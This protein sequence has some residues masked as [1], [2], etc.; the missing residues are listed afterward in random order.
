MLTKRNVDAL[1]FDTAGPAQQIEWDGKLSGFGCRVYPTGA[2]SFVVT[3]RTES[4]LA[5]MLVLGKYG[6]LTV[7]QGRKLAQERLA[8]VARGEDPAETKRQAR[9]GDT[10]RDLCRAYLDRHAKKKR[11]S[12]REDERR[13]NKH[14]LPTLGAK[15]VADLKKTDLVRLHARISDRAP[16]EANRVLDLLRLMLNLAPD[17]GMLPE[18]AANPAAKVRK[19]KETS[20]DRW[21]TPEELPALVEAIEAE[22]SPYVVAAFK[23]YL[24]TGCRRNELLR[25]RWADVDLTRREIRLTEAKTGTRTVPLSDQAVA[26]FKEL[27]RHIGNVYVFPGRVLKAQSDAKA[28]AKPLLNV[29]KAWRRVRARLWLAMNPGRLAELREQA[30]RDVQ[31]KHVPKTPEVVEAR[32]LK[33]AEK[34]AHGPDAV[35]LHDLRRTVGAWMATSGKSLPVVGKVLGHTSPAATTVYARI[36]ESAARAALEEHGERI[37][38]LLTGQTGA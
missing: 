36:A 5:R 22:E 20:R 9:L 25:L 23:L 1:T 16:L 10:V 34:E 38:P 14:I 11:R 30:E 6:K 4:G 15:K 35:R 33:L 37:G 18:E 21:V 31:R 19:N 8:A 3:Y 27:P 2:K 24:L 28:E 7:D 32:L 29:S 17:W 13:I 26:I 12:W